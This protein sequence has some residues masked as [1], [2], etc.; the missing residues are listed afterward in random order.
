MGLGQA[1]MR[2]LQLSSM[3]AAEDQKVRSLTSHL[4][5]ITTVYQIIVAEITILILGELGK[6]VFRDISNHEINTLERQSKG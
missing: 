6:G 3:L 5:I 1:L 4:P 2:V